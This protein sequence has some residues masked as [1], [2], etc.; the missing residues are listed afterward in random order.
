MTQNRVGAKEPPNSRLD[1]INVEREEH[2]KDTAQLS[3]NTGLN[4]TK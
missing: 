4:Y 2:P 3:N 1:V